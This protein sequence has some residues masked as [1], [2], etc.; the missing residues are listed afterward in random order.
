[1]CFLVN[2]VVECTDYNDS[3]QKI[4]M[5]LAECE[6][7]AEYRF[8]GLTDVFT[9]YQQPYEKIIIGCQESKD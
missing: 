2:G 7:D 4:Y 1:M 8:Y 9:L 3:N 6:R 5:T